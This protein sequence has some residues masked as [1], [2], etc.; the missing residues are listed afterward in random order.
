MELYYA[1][2]AVDRTVAMSD[3]ALALVREAGTRDD[4]ARV[5]EL[6]RVVLERPHLHAQR[7]AT[8]DELIAL[9]EAADDPIAAARSLVYR[10][11][12]HLEGGDTRAGAA[13]Y[14]RARTLAQEHGIVPVLVA[15]DFA[16][17]A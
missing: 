8:A 16:D 12:D 14:A 1:P 11:K 15:L 5:L 7:L 13:D 3:Q 10:G 17:S 6:R 2:D 9:A 4:V